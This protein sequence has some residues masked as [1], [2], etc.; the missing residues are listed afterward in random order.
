MRCNRTDALVLAA[1]LAGCGGYA[2]PEHHVSTSRVTVL[3]PDDSV[4]AYAL[5]DHRAR[6]PTGIRA[7]PD[8]GRARVVSDTARFYLCFDAGR[9]FV[10]LASLPRPTHTSSGDAPWILG[11]RGDTVFVRLFR[12]E[13]NAS[14]IPQ[15][16]AL[17]PGR[18]PRPL[19][20]APTTLET[21]LSNALLGCT[22]R[23]DSVVALLRR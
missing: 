3:R 7:F 8:G 6:R 19:S 9:G 20:A 18:E 11:L 13:R 10:E 5:R 22:R 14:T 4:T 2:A 23:V 21:G 12:A 17:V 15:L 1:L 16:Y